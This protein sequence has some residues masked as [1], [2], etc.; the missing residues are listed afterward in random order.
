MKMQLALKKADMPDFLS[1]RN[2]YIDHIIA[3]LEIIIAGINELV[4]AC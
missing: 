1:H 3:H 4:V 2:S